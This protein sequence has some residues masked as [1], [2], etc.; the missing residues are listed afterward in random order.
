MKL[1]KKIDISDVFMFL[2]LVLIG[3]GL[4]FWFGIGPALAIPGGLLLCMGYLAGAL[5]GK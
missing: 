5:G 2:G 3:I 1:I 4:F